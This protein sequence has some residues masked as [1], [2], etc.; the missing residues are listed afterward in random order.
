MGVMMICL[1]V[2][3][4][5]QNVADSL[6]S[7]QW[8]SKQSVFEQI[9][10]DNI[11][12]VTPP[13]GEKCKSV[14]QHKSIL[15]ALDSI[16]T[17]ETK[18]VFLYNNK[19]E[20][21]GTETYQKD[22]IGTWK[23]S[24]KTEY[25]YDE[26]GYQTKITTYQRSG[27]QWVEY[28]KIM[29]LFD[30]DGNKLSE[31]RYLWQSNQW[32]PFSAKSEYSYDINGNITESI[33]YVPNGM[34]WEASVKVT[35][36]Y[37]FWGQELLYEQYQWTSD[38]WQGVLK[39]ESSYSG[40]AD[41][42]IDSCYTCIFFNWNGSDWQKNYKTEFTFTP[43]KEPRD[44]ILSYWIDNQWVI[45]YKESRI[46]DENSFWIEYLE[47]A[48]IDATQNQWDTLE[49]VVMQHAADGLDT[50]TIVYED[51][52]DGLVPEERGHHYYN[53]KGLKIKVIFEHW[54]NDEW[55]F[56][57]Q[58]LM[59]YDSNGVQISLE[60]YQW[61]G[62]QWLITSKRIEDYDSN[63]NLIYLE[64]Y[65]ASGGQLVG[66]TKY[67]RIYNADKKPILLIN[68]QWINQQW[69]PKDSTIFDYDP[70][71]IEILNESYIWN[72]TQWEKKLKKITTQTN[73]LADEILTPNTYKYFYKTLSSN[74]LQLDTLL[75]DWSLF[76]STV[77]YYSTYS[78]T[79]T[80]SVVTLAADN[81]SYTS[82]VLN[83]KVDAGDYALSEVGFAYKALS[84]SDYT[85]VNAPL[86]TNFSFLLNN[87]QE[88]MKYRY[89]AFAI[90]VL[91]DTIYG[92]ILTFTLPQQPSNILNTE[93][94]KIQLY[95]NPATSQLKIKNVQLKDV[96]NVEIID[97]LGRVQ[98]STSV[99]QQ[100]EIIIDVSHLAKGIYFIKIGNWIEKFLVN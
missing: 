1:N 55:V 77:Y 38:A 81:I 78:L 6:F 93:Q 89:K 84:D 79:K 49:K 98:Q 44:Y 29:Y 68:Y 54:E 64:L 95:P 20:H 22:M 75:S 21:A 47:L 12:I 4:N 80:V 33:N 91:D 18:E 42:T 99:N 35:M 24:S 19:G 97:I 58:R 25:E 5:A 9:K 41:G 34:Q 48:A 70:N 87:L 26:N 7:M 11:S 8:K 94:N 16:V 31:E 15:Q 3:L 96:E 60:Y 46:Y 23:G 82:A 10:K 30:N 62:T 83:G 14:K 85:F 2:S 27:S 65:T 50:L 28:I 53:D 36:A 74:Q 76:D 56:S 39:R 69:Q 92:K 51:D 37:D 52:G 66:S 45:N 86:A 90:N 72:G 73:D 61:D 57:T 43:K 32:T 63:N 88:G 100:S 13:K 71:L 17:A 40:Y 59:E 67:T